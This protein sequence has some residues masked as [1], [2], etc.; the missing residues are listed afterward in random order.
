M[1]IKTLATFETSWEALKAAVADGSIRQVLHSGDKIPVTL[2]NG[3][4]VVF[5][6]TYDE[7]GNLFFVTQDCLKDEHCMNK[8]A[9]RAVAGR[10][11]KCADTSMKRYSPCSL[12][13]YRQ[14]SNLPLSY[15][16]WTVRE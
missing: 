14:L 16:S 10:K 12:T 2:K 8:T 4:E 11:P 13:N 6:A 5:E 3:E 7:N 9:P 15:R 1:I